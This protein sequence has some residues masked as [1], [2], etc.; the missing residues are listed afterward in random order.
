MAGA[1]PTERRLALDRTGVA[2]RVQEVGTGP[3]V[4]FVHGASNSGASWAGLVA[5][6]DGF[7]CILLD[8][9]GCG[10]SEP[11]AARFDDV[12][13]LGAFAE[14]VLV[15]VLDGLELARAHVVSTSFGGYLAL[16]TA[17]A[18]PQ[19]V[20][21]LVHFGWTVGAPVGP[22]PL[23]MR[24]ASMPGLGRLM[25]RVPP[26]ERAVRALFRRIGLRQAMDGGRVPDEI[27]A[28][29]LALLRDTDTMRNEL[30]AGPR[31]ITLRGMADDVLLPD[32]VL[33]AVEA[34]AFFLWGDEDPFGGAD[35][36]RAF[37]ARLPDASLELVPGA[38]HAVWIDDPDRAAAAVTRFLPRQ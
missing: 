2:V 29:Y 30:R 27:I 9:P 19:R 1:T 10:L 6:L 3:P 16:R 31:I 7:R 18:H 37:V 14:S 15:D 13:A 23:V 34:P 20:D 4:L 35:V 26:T 8:R 24:V 17:A 32:S 33:S 25:A 28:T 22:V 12:A 21:R 36:A 11:V 5:R 38:G